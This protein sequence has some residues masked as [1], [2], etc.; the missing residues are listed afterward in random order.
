MR[1]EVIV[2]PNAM[3]KNLKTV[4]IAPLTHTLKRY[5]SRVVSTFAGQAGEIVLDQIRAV[6]KKSLKKKLGNVSPAVAA[7]IKKVLV[8]MFS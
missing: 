8:T 6:D 4:L 5:P 1:P 2:S 7:D 3:N